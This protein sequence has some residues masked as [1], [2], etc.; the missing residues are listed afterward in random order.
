MAILVWISE[1]SLPK[2]PLINHIIRK[3]RFQAIF[4]TAPKLLL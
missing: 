3:K 2:F 1:S 4:R